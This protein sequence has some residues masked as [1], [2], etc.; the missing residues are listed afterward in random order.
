MGLGDQSPLARL[1]DL[2]GMILLLGVSHGNNTSMHLAEHRSSFAGKLFYPQGAPVIVE[3]KREWKIFQD[4][5]TNCEDF[6]KIGEAFD[7]TGLSQ[8]GTA[9][10]GQATLM[11]SRDVVDFTVEALPRFRGEAESENFFSI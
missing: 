10:Y 4:L 5:L 6:E 7:Q 2:D 1:Y 9:G 11:K 8:K 3:G